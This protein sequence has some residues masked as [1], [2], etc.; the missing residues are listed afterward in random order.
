MIIANLKTPIKSRGCDI[1]Y[2][3]AFVLLVIISPV[4]SRLPVKCR[5]FGLVRSWKDN[6]SGVLFAKPLRK[7]LLNQGVTL[8]VF[9]T[10]SRGIIARFL[11]A[12]PLRKLLLN[13]GVTLLVFWNVGTKSRTALLLPVGFRKLLWNQWVEVSPVEWSYYLGV[14]F[15]WLWEASMYIVQFAVYI[16]PCF[17]GVFCHIYTLFIPYFV[18]KN[19]WIFSHRNKVEERIATYSCDCRRKSLTPKDF[20]AFN[21]HVRV[22]AGTQRVCVLRNSLQVIEL[23]GVFGSVWRVESLV[24][25][26]WAS[27]GARKSQKPYR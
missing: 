21:W 20:S 6:S 16:L 1:R 26:F 14:N 15:N 27:D 25:I 13:Q 10:W 19:T 8:L 22:R 24:I 4:R 2:F 12:K 17:Y 7:L 18:W 23:Q 11:V 9:W 5:V 3:A